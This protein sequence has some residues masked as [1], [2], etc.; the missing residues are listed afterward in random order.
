[1]C[2]NSWDPSDATVACRQL[3]FSATG[4]QALFGFEDVPDGTGP[5]WLDEV[6]CAG[7]EA[8]LIDCPANPLGIH[9]CRNSQDAGV[10]CMTGT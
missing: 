1:M 8:K 7:T 4:A 10:S 5:I 9:D 3:G 2:D 6:N